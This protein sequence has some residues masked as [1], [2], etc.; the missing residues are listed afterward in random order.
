MFLIIFFVP[1]AFCLEQKKKKKKGILNYTR[2]GN[3]LVLT[4]VVF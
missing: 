3:K 1:L 2:G 4:T